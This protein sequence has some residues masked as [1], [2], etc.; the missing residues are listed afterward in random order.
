MIE[1]KIDTEI[2]IGDLNTMKQIIEIC[3]KRGAFQLDE[4]VIS[5]NLSSKINQAIEKAKE[6]S[7]SLTPL[8]ILNHD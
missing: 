3:A 8:T 6:Q 7:E 2:T 5:G 4:F 1:N